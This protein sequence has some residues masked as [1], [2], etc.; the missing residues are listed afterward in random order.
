MA[1]A[2]GLVVSAPKAVRD[3]RWAPIVDQIDDGALVPHLLQV[4]PQELDAVD[5]GLL[6][7]I[8]AEHRVAEV[9]AAVAQQYGERVGSGAGGMGQDISVLGPKE[10]KG[11][12]FDGVVLL[13]PEELLDGLGGKVGD[14]YVAMTRPTQRL[15]LIAAG[16]IPAGIEG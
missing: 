15:R 10:A 9:R 1:V 16:D 7:V 4:L 12:E 2:A 8:A 5:G 14:L 6:A 11:L 3:G 13:E